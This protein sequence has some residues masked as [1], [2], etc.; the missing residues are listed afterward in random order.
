M[1]VAR[2]RGFEL[3]LAIFIQVVTLAKSTGL[4]SMGRSS[5]QYRLYI[6]RQSRTLAIFSFTDSFQSQ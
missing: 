5:L 4:N 1:L 6:I 3:G 2:L